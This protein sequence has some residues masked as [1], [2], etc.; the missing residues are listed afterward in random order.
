VDGDRATCPLGS[1]PIHRRPG[2]PPRGRILLMLRPE[3]VRV[4]PDS[5]DSSQSGVPAVVDSVE[6][7]GHD[8]LVRA[9]LV[10]DRRRS[11]SVTCRTT[12]P[13]ATAG[14]RVRITVAGQGL[15]FPDDPGQDTG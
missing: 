3:Q 4:R 11:V 7:F 10:D 13:V 12:D 15:V 9:T 8:C 2:D 5:T 14:A 1:V 6:F